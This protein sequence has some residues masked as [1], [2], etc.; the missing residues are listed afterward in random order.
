MSGRFARWKSSF[1]GTC[2]RVPVSGA[3]FRAYEG[4]YKATWTR[5]YKL[6]WRE[7]G[8]PN[9]LDAEV[10]SDQKVVNK[11]LSRFFRVAGSQCWKQM[12]G[13]FARWK[14]SFS[15]TCVRVPDSGREREFF[16]DNLMVR[17]HFMIDM[18]WWTGLA[19]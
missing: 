5:K 15:S 9:H 19:P 12:S 6:P 8:P 13:R 2:A 14:S 16:I 18:I 1:S 3:H 11:E 7:A 10:D 4:R 17:I